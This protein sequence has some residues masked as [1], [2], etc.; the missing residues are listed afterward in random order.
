MF[1]GENL[2]KRSQKQLVAEIISDQPDNHSPTNRKLF[3]ADWKKIA[4]IF[5]NRLVVQRSDNLFCNYG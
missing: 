4:N 1:S 5:F 2:E 3:P